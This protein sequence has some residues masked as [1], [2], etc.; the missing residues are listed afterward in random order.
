MIQTYEELMECL[1]QD[2]AASYR[3]RI[4]VHGF[5]DD[6]W[7]WQRSM[8]YSEYYGN[9]AKRN[10]LYKLPAIFMRR[11]FASL[12]LK[13]GFSTP[14]RNIG[15]GFSVAHYGLLVINGNTVIGEN[16][17]VHEGVC[18]GTTN[19]SNNA[20]RIGNNVFIGSGA[21]IIGDIKIADD[22][23]IAA[24]AV[25]VKSITEPGTTWAGVPAKKVS[26]QSSHSNL[27]PLLKLD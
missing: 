3:L 16:C 20:P 14:Y 11:R 2:A 5:R 12:S 18:I 15:K 25:V 17:R 6:I 10:V 8:R 7:R 1:R 13:L 26:N 21:K 27:S 4:Q 19:G 24:G 23:A 22:V 9:R